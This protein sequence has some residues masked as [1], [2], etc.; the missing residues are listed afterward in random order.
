M[1]PAT[2]TVLFICAAALLVAR[3]WMHRNSPRRT[4]DHA[5][6]VRQNGAVVPSTTLPDNRFTHDEASSLETVR[7]RYHTAVSVQLARE[8][9]ATPPPRPRHPPPRPATAATTIDAPP[10]PPPLLPNTINFVFLGLWPHKGSSM[11]SSFRKNL[12]SWRAH[13]DMAAFPVKLWSLDDVLALVHTEG[14][15]PRQVVDAFGYAS[16]IQKADLAR[17][18]ILAAHG[19]WYFDLDTGVQ[20]SG[21]GLS[22]CTNNLRTLLDKRSF[23]LAQKSGALFWE[24]GPLSMQER[25]NSARRACRHGSQEYPL[26][27]SNYALYA[28]DAKGLQFFSTVLD[29]AACRVLREREAKGGCNQEYTVLFTTGP[30]VT[31]E[32]AQGQRAV[33]KVCGGSRGY[34]AAATTSADALNMLVVDPKSLVVNANSFTW[35][36]A[37]NS[38]LRHRHDE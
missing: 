15:F 16:P 29:L 35:R 8:M 31:S 37:S 12:A 21:S 30:D 23:G 26:R 22:S 4:M 11:P 36:G 20:C 33:G 17:Y 32:V 24:R 28:R 25:D 27:L 6:V 1:R 38:A 7:R 9:A 10:S 13:N 2:A 18:C 19:G 34:G 14:L 5:E 3:F